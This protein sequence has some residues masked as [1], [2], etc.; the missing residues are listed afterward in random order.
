MNNVKQQICES[1]ASLYS[2]EYREDQLY[3]FEQ[4]RTDIIQWKANVLQSVN[5]N[6]AKD[7]IIRNLNHRSGLV[8]MDWA[9]KFV[10][11]K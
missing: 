4:A 9:M 10:Q 6:K 2:K 7:D 8:V 5:Q 11:M 3:D 1:S